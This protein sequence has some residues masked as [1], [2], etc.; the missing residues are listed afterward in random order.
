MLPP[1]TKIVCTI[2]P[3][4]HSR[5]LLKELIL[6]GMNVARL[7]LSHG[8]HA[9]HATV[10]KSLKS[11]AKSLNRPVAIML[12]L[13]GPKIRT[14]RIKGGGMAVNA[15]DPLTITTRSVEGETGLVS[16]T[17]R[18]ITKDL[19]PG[20]TI[21][22][23]DGLIELKVQSKNKTDLFCEVINGGIIGE[24]KGINLPGITTGIQA[25]TKKDKKDL[26]FG[27]A[28]GIDFAALSFVRSARDVEILKRLLKKKG[29]H[30][31]VISKIEKPQALDQLEEILDACE[32]IMVARGDLGVELS[33]EQVPVAQKKMITLANQKRKMVIT[34][35][36]MLESM[37]EHPLPTRAEAS[38]VA[39]AILDGT[40]AIMLSGETSVG[41]YPVRTVKMMAR[42]ARVTE[43][44]FPATATFSRRT[45]DFSDTVSE[46]ACIAAENLGL[47][48]IAAFSQSGF[49]ARLISKYRPSVPIIAF[50]TSEDV[51]RALSLSWGVKALL[52]PAMDNSDMMI[53]AMEDHLRKK[54]LVRKKDRIVIVAGHPLIKRGKTNLMKLHVIGEN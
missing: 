37:T 35:T 52:L 6:A 10:V 34:A 41:K 9:D 1:R 46:A 51:Q 28:L 21:L 16:T 30:I 31:P 54:R 53:K 49:T 42:I 3:A 23:D 45:S 2:G 20:D 40:D 29:A 4:T 17:Y 32:G 13:Q 26:D 27:L 22:M 48:A 15:H 33:P 7:N 43:R 25:V 36:Q 8:T 12:D 50:T 19:Q 11:L 38:D 5:K 18:G 47:K 44:N 14:G 24:H 39:N